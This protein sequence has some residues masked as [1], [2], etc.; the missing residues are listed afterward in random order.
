ME[1]QITVL[2]YHCTAGEWARLVLTG[3]ASLKS[4]NEKVSGFTSR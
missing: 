3:I 4:V 2:L 1:E